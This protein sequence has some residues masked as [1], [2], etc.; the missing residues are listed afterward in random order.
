MKLNVSAVPIWCK[1][2]GGF[3]ES[4][5]SSVSERNLKKLVGI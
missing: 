1:K 5:W 2:P 4:Y 3:L